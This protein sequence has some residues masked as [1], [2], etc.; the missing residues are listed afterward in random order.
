MSEID[1]EDA[2]GHLWDVVVI[3]AGAGGGAAGYELSRRGMSVL[4]IDYGRLLYSDPNVLKRNPRRKHGEGECPLHGYWPVL[5][6]PL[7]PS[8]VL[9][10]RF[11]MGC[12]SGGSTAL[13]GMTLE[14]FRYS[15][16]APADT[17][18]L[19][20]IS[21]SNWPLRYEELAPFY[22]EAESIFRVRGTPDPLHPAGRL[23][24]PPS[25]ND[26]ERSLRDR[27]DR[28]GLHPYRTHSA[29]E[30]EL[31]CTG[32]RWHVCPRD[33]RN[34]AGRML[35]KPAMERHGAHFLAECK[36]LRLI[37]SSRAV[38]SVECSRLGRTIRIRA[39]I[40]I[41]AANAFFSP[42][43]LLLSANARF[44][45]GLANGSG[46]V[47]R[48]LMLHVSDTLAAR[49]L[50]PLPA[51]GMKHG[52]FLTDFYVYGNTKLGSISVLP[53]TTPLVISTIVEDFPYYSNRVLAKSDGS[54]AFEYYYPSE[55]KARNT[56]LLSELRRH[57]R[58]W[59]DL[60]HLTPIGTLNMT[61]ACGTCR[62][63][64]DSHTS[65]VDANCRAHDLDNL[66]IL[67]ASWFPSSGGINPALTIIA[68]SLRVCRQL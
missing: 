37:E 21:P 60:D 32:C 31:G 64:S 53:F 55:L 34:D 35:I 39:R 52:I 14:R 28:S 61:H 62:L 58:I 24:R 59:L 26:A 68:N 9:P 23:R 44:P 16:F 54:V 30:G 43:L 65:V 42:A 51:T 57:T 66:Y 27:L 18:A 63:G 2:C 1:P 46:L 8:H 4:F 3:G 67:D 40:F 6:R 19:G 38:R 33:C 5:P 17:F 36:A 13:F 25:E 47:G 50:I 7:T 20:K 41:L 49:P 10:G 48:N 12:G 11:P 45:S 15:D 56:L 29:C 22:D